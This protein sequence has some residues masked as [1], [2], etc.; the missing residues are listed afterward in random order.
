MTRSESIIKL[1][2]AL[3]KTQAVMEGATKDATNPHFKSKYADLAAVWDACRE[4]LSKHGLSILQPVSAEGPKVTV[5]TI[6]LHTSGEFLEE[7]LTLTAAQDTPQAIGS[8]ITYGRRYGLS[9]MVG[10]APED[11]DG[12]AAS[13]KGPTVAVPVATAPEGYQSWLDDLTAVADTGYDALSKAFKASPEPFRVHL[14]TRDAQALVKLKAR[15]KVAD[16]KAVP[17]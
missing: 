13:K 14:S 11:D 5:R 3:A 10:I 1:A 16:E 17:A 6:L 2:E 15:A 8:V 4:P 9:S 12:E 7:A